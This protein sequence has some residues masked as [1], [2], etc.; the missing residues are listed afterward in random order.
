MEKIL[1][2][3]LKNGKFQNVPAARSKIMSCIPGRR[4][5]STEVAL[6]LELVRAGISGWKMHHK[7]T[8]RPDF[9]FP[10]QSLAVFVDGCFWHGCSRCGHI[11]KTR[12]KFWAAKILRN[13]QRDARNSRILR[14]A[15]VH[16][17]RVWE[18]Q[19]K[20]QS[21]KQRVVQKLC[22]TINLPLKRSLTR[23]DGSLTVFTLRYHAQAFKESANRIVKSKSHTD[24]A[25]D[26]NR[27]AVLPSPTKRSVEFR[28]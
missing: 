5:R 11:P 18:H 10:E 23:C 22:K 25:R 8:G 15:G 14:K 21:D 2:A 1:K 26:K 3:K 28:S 6:R 13:R 17:F 24:L 19:L 27:R 4:N 12:T 16:I 7:I 20:K 9:F